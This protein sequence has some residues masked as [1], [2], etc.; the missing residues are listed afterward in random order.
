MTLRKMEFIAEL[1]VALGFLFGI[2]FL[3][4]KAV[5]DLF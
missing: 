4:W 5:P 2:I 3:C 1:I